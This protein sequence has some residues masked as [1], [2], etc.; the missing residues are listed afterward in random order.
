MKRLLW[1]TAAILLL[2]PSCSNS[3]KQEI[4]QVP[5]NEVTITG[6]FW[7]CRMN[8]ELET[9]VPFSLKHCDAAIKRFEQCADFLS[10]SSTELP[11]THR[12]ISSDL[13][14]V[15]EGAAYSLML[16]DDPETESLIDSFAVLAAKV[17]RPDGYLYINHICGNPNPDEMGDKPYSWVVHSHELYNVG[18]LYEAAVAYYQATGKTNLL[19]IAVKNARHVNKVFFEGDPNYNGGKPVNQAPG[20]EEIELALCKL[21]KVTG[22][23]L[24]LDMAK[25]FLDIRGVTYRPEGEG[26]MSPEYA[27]QHAPVALQREVAGHSVRAGY[28]YTAMAQVDALTG[29]SDYAEAL[30]SIWDNLVSTRMHI[31]GGLGAV[32]SVEGFGA[33]YELP[34]KEAYDETC[35]AVANVFFNEGMFLASGDA[36]FLDIAELSIFNNA[37]AGINLAGDRFFYV[38]PLE[39]DGQWGF[40]HGKT[41]R[42]EWFGC[43]CCPPNISRM[44][45]QTPGY[46]YA[47]TDDAIY[48]TLYGSSRT[49]I[50]LDCGKVELNQTSDYPF[51][52][53]V[54]VDVNPGAGSRFSLKLRIPTWADGTGN[55]IPGGL[56]T[57]RNRAGEPVRIKVNGKNVRYRIVDGFAVIDRYWDAGD[58]VELSIPMPVRYVAADS[59]IE[60]DRNATAV[61]IGPLVY[62]AEECDNADRVQNLAINTEGWG[63]TCMSTIS[64]GPLDG[65]RKVICPGSRDITMIPYYAWDNREDSQS[66]TVWVKNLPDTTRTEKD[67]ERFSPNS[68][69]LKGMICL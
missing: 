53:E 59:R 15:I 14:K 33:K 47:Y 12:F 30:N 66:M 29:R 34:N 43:A 22:D 16:K 4:I 64:G 40:N 21:Y 68:P 52:G 39:A 63:T 60:A 18:H 1:G 5:F 61:T 32:R 31:T 36:R 46:M 49:A 58:R 7:Q 27:Q 41:G 28:L 8:S 38:N 26:V 9:T 3:E 25:K 2:S 65:V 37:L 50:T 10:G 35:A 17:Q 55:F 69:S 44:I 23:T 48:L 45:L 57:F 54:T 11:E 62:C 67:L 42:A 24:Y 56:Y 6:G 19:D 51:S 13:Y 20:H